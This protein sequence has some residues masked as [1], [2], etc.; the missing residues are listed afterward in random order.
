MRPTTRSFQPLRG[1]I[2][3]SI[4]SLCALGATSFAGADAP[5]PSGIEENFA[6]QVA[7]YADGGEIP[8]DDWKAPNKHAFDTT[9]VTGNSSSKNIPHLRASAG[10]M[11]SMELGD[12]AEIHRI[13]DAYAGFFAEPVNLE[14]GSSTYTR[15]IWPPVVVALGF[16]QRYDRPEIESAA[17]AW[18][19][20]HAAKWAI[21]TGWGEEGRGFH[22]GTRRG[23]TRW[24]PNAYSALARSATHSEPGGPIMWVEY[25]SNSSFLSLMLG[26]GRTSDL[27][28]DFER[29]V[30][31]WVE[32]EFGPI[33]RRD[34]ALRTDMRQ[35][36]A[37][38][39]PGDERA[40]AALRRLLP[41]VRYTAPEPVWIWRTTEE[42]GVFG[43]VSYNN[44][45][46]DF[47]RS[48]VW[49]RRHGAY[50]ILI[51]DYPARK[52]QGG[53]GRTHWRLD[54]ETWSWTGPV[55]KPR[56][57]SLE[58]NDWIDAPIVWAPNGRKIYLVRIGPE[59]ATIHDLAS[60]ARKEG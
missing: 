36:I 5:R 25:C 40:L 24:R 19:D 41:R 21:A 4:V 50:R 57:W 59:G 52:N 55:G 10:L 45:S 48:K 56:I 22:V 12:T 9:N 38:N 34:E 17:E 26:E 13:L 15:W 31:T 3:L 51:E 39:E 43:E 29:P 11:R 8:T 7:L 49:Q 42:V 46:T 16:A 6:R 60:S 23:T 47:L 27:R 18:L 2:I 54:P 20:S 44:S 30:L 58:A 32:R 37:W 14:D 1:G 28:S 35:V 33:W 53:G